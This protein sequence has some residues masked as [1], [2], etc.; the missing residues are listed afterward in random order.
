[1]STT[2]NATSN[3]TH[4]EQVLPFIKLWRVGLMAA[5][6]AASIN[7]VYFLVTKSVLGIPYIIPMGGP[8]GPLMSLPALLIIIF[9]VVPAFGATI[10]LAMLGRYSSR[11]F[12]VFW[13]ISVG[14]FVIS[15]MLPLGLP[16]S[17]ETSTKIGLSLMHIPA[18]AIILGI[19]SRWGR[20]K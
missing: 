16:S 5:V 12:R 4:I 2:T 18:G 11:P 1:M 9:N 14:V 20:E 3:S 17:V 6:G 19:L 13:I 10:L 7:L 15:F 8:S